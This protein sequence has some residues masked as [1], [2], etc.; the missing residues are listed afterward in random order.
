MFMDD[1]P[2]AIL[3]AESHGEAELQLGRATAWRDVNTAAYRSNESYVFAGSDLNVVKIE[4]NWPRLRS[5][6]PAGF[7]CS[8]AAVLPPN[9]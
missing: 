8:R 4:D 5:E 9:I 1:P 3:F 7:V 2:L 6:E